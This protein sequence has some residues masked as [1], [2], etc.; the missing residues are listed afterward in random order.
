MDVSLLH[1]LNSYHLDVINS[2][3]FLPNDD[4]IS[5]SADQTIKVWNLKNDVLGAFFFDNAICISVLA[6][7]KLASGSVDGQV[8]IWDLNEKTLIK[9]LG[10]HPKMV[11]S[12]K[13][14][15][16]GRLVSMSVDGTIRIWNLSVNATR[17]CLR[18]INAQEVGVTMSPVGSLSNGGIVTCSFNE[19]NGILRSWNSKTGRLTR[20]MD[21][22]LAWVSSLLV[23]S[24]DQVVLGAPGVIKIFDMDDASVN[25]VLMVDQSGF[26]QAA[27]VFS[28]TLLPNGL[29][30][31]GISWTDSYIQVWN[32]Q[33]G[34][35]VNMIQT[36]H[37][38]TT[39]ALNVSQD[40]SMVATASADRQIKIWA[41]F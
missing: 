39:L 30:L 37:Q 17:D 29:I 3:Q 12:L 25:R 28:L 19:K 20:Q 1:V 10:K 21:T 34:K 18:S 6:N 8:K 13:P 9:T 22:G 32:P 23:L 40:G 2:I 36:G 26:E 41:L 33:T 7:G 5:C 27:R 35:L 31:N 24:N 16:G 14:I 38:G 11:H 15:Q 4:L